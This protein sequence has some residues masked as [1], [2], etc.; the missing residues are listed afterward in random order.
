MS[1]QLIARALG[2]RVSTHYD[3]P[4]ELWP[5]RVDSGQIQQVLLN[6]AL[7]A[8]D[9]MPDG[10]RFE[11]IGRNQQL[12]A[13]EA[14]RRGE[15]DGDY[16]TL[17]VVDTGTGMDEATRRRC[18]EPFYT[19]KGDRG[20][21]LGLAMVYGMTQRHGVDIDIRSAPGEGTTFRLIF[22]LTAPAPQSTGSVRIQKIPTHTK[23]L[24]VD[25]DPLLLQ[26]LREILVNEGHQV[27]T[28][29]GGRA[30][31]DAFMDA[32]ESGQPF[33]VVITDLGM[34]HVD[35]R[36]VAA[37]IS[38]AAPGTA[39]IMLTGWGQRLAASGEIP[40][41]VSVVMSKPPKVAE[42]RQWLAEFAGERQPD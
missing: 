37:A 8:R 11:L 14:K 34:P 29:H 41:G 19:T 10:G 7:N 25:D 40:P 9:A 22:P 16:V 4:S 2:D 5:V 18:L 36:A 21:G 27:Q 28:A 1:K 32:Y 17:Q 38:A 33:P 20:S 30:G 23:I 26:S 6:L 15:R 24:V 13:H 35:G 3:L 12:S 42:L 31:I 39:I